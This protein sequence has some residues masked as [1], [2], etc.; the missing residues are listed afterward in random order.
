MKAGKIVGTILVVVLAIGLA[1]ARFQ[2]KQARYER[3]EQELKQ[4]DQ[5]FRAGAH[6]LVSLAKDQN[7]A[8]YLSAAVD[9]FHDDAFDQE[10]NS[11]LL[12][13]NTLFGLMSAKAAKAGREDVSRALNELKLKAGFSDENCF[14]LRK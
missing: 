9:E 13:R 7:A 6:A 12:Y 1:A 4:R 3:L 11:A 5:D 8:K 10:S 14:Q 2:A